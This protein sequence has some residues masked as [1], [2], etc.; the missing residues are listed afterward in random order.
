MKKDAINPPH[1]KNHPSGVEAIT[2]CG[3]MN[4]NLGN[5]FKYLYRCDSKEKLL[6]DMHKALWYVRHEKTLLPPQTGFS[7]WIRRLFQPHDYDAYS[8]GSEPIKRIL[9]YER[10]YS[11]HMAAALASI[12]EAHRYPGNIEP[13]LRAEHSV[14]RMIGIVDYRQGGH[15]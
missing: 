3:E 1:Y 4:F 11:G 13:L 7:A 15:L 8:E 14:S 2:V 10:R 6:E 5:S 9:A 12:Y